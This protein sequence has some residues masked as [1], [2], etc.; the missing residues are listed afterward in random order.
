[1][2][3]QNP[4][5][6]DIG[7]ESVP[8]GA[9]LFPNKSYGIA[10]PASLTLSDQLREGQYVDVLNEASRDTTDLVT[11]NCPVT[12]F[13]DEGATAVQFINNDDNSDAG[14]TYT[15]DQKEKV[16]FY[17]K[18]TRIYIDKPENLAETPKPVVY[19]TY[20]FADSGNAGFSWT[21]GDVANATGITNNG[22]RKSV[23]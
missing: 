9:T 5:T 1:M 23:V 7:Y 22:D 14:T 10:G 12:P 6:I 18:G 2:S 11:V 15:I 4:K 13:L 3:G 8:D 21:D 19:G 17:R 16:R 20:S